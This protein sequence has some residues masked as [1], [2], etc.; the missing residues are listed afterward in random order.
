MYFFFHNTTHIHTQTASCWEVLIEFHYTHT[1]QN[2]HNNTQHTHTSW[3]VSI[4]FHYTHKNTYVYAGF[5]TQ[6]SYWL[7]YI[8]VRYSSEKDCLIAQKV[9]HVLLLFY[10]LLFRYVIDKNL[11]RDSKPF[12]MKWNNFGVTSSGTGVVLACLTTDFSSRGN[13][14]VIII[15]MTYF[16]FDKQDKIQVE[17]VLRITIDMQDQDS[18]DTATHERATPVC[19]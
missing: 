5:G 13:D 17:K 19:V 3:E 8:S 15:I 11:S 4:E 9:L 14:T 10:C 16:L 7:C 6:P 18:H 12:D 2:I 1:T